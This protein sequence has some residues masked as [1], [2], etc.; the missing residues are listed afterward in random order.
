MVCLKFCTTNINWDNTSPF[1]PNIK[2]AKVIK[3]YDGDTITIASK[4][5]LFDKKYYRFSVRLAR[6]DCPE[7]RTKDSNEKEFA[8]K[9]KESLERLI[10]NKYV[11]LNVIKTDKY[12]RLLAEVYF[13]NKSINDWLLHNHLAVEYDGGKKN[14]PDDWGLYNSKVQFC[15]FENFTHT[16]R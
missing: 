15:T 6:I 13:E 2:R 1:I 4:V 14:T 3:V 8:V 12:G 10:L 5:S 9:A 7:L 16:S 11:K